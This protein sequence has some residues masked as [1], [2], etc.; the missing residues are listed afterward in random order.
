ML[1]LDVVLLRFSAAFLLSFAFGVIRQWRG[2]PIGFGTFIF[3]S[4]GSC[5][6]A[7]TAMSLEAE[8]PL[9]L[10]GAIVTGVGFLGAGA[11]LRTADRIVGFTSAATIW[12]FAVFG[13]TMGVGE[14]L[15]AGLLYASIW[16]VTLIDRAME[17]RWFGAHQRRLTLD[18]RADAPADDTLGL[19][20]LPG[21]ERALTVA[22]ERERGIVT[23]V[24]SVER[25]RLLP[26]DLV[27][28]LKR[29]DA[30]MGFRFE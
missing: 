23:L 30:V 27:E 1:P 22:L 9:P 26:G 7:L 19:L 13:L 21:R 10:L 16:I 2:K 29:T 28:R 14:Y 15:V 8:N 18:L 24:F 11:L 17:K 4:M 25:P 12:I 6:I 3:V 5:G 20:G